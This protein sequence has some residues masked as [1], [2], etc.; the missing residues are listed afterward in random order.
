MQVKYHVPKIQEIYGLEI[1]IEDLIPSHH[2]KI[3]Q[4]FAY[5]KIMQ[6]KSIKYPHIIRSPPEI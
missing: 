4:H 2:I 1:L 3:F 6:C 5:G